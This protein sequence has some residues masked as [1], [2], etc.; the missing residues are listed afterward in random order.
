[1][2]E[3]PTMP[4]FTDAYIAD[5]THLTNEEHGVYFRLLMFAWRSRD[6]TLP[7]DE[8]RIAI[9]VGLTPHRWSKMRDTIM[10]FWEET[11]EGFS[12]KK[13]KKVRNYVAR[14]RG[15][16]SK[17]GSASASAKRLKS[18]NTASTDVENVLPKNGQSAQ[19]NVNTT[20]NNPNPNP[21]GSDLE[22]ESI[23]KPPPGGGGFSPFDW[24][25]ILQAVGYDP[26]G[27]IP[28]EWADPG[29][30]AE[31]WLNLG[32]SPAQAITAAK[33]SRKVHSEPP[34]TPQALNSFMRQAA[35]TARPSS[36]APAPIE[37]RAAFWAEQI[38][39]GKPVVPSAVSPELARHMIGAELVTSDQLR[40]LGIT[41]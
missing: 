27:H 38:N 11:P 40:D 32:L 16:K 22:I 35:S 34:Q 31:A 13:Q 36:R 23:S 24:D 12:Q 33:A 28:D 37:T 20:V 2:A 9:M 19:H 4:L 7:L 18:N 3:F 30:V 6:C 1:M 41:A 25:A 15:K 5:T 39:G 10:A 8:N 17:A 29:E 26:T 14:T 21:N